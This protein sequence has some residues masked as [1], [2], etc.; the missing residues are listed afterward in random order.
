MTSPESKAQG[1]ALRK[2][3]RDAT[4]ISQSFSWQLN[5]YAIAAGAAGVALLACAVP[6]EG[7][8]VCTKATGE[9][10]RTNTLPLYLIDRQ[11][12]SFNIAQQADSTFVSTTAKA[13]VLFWWNRGFFTP[14]SAAAEV[15]LSKGFPAD[16]AFGEEIGPGGDFGKGGSY[17]LLFT[18]GKGHLGSGQGGGTLLKHR[19]NLD[20]SHANYVGFRF[21]NTGSLHYGWVR[22]KIAIEAGRGNS[23]NTAIHLLGY[24]YEST[25]DTAIAAGSC[26]SE[27][28]ASKGA[29]RTLP[30][31][32]PDPSL[33]MLA[34]GGQ[35]ISMWR[36]P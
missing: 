4:D 15:L 6:A 18:Y 32:A 36:K 23:K 34:L 13:S 14:N 2:R 24:A 7:S 20:L 28:A 10:L 31:D 26:Q 11:V 17:G 12:P 35:A 8:P 22:L 25:P 27:L 19:G 16:V 21:S 9:L 29:Q 3:Q 33:G 5:A 30:A 1:H